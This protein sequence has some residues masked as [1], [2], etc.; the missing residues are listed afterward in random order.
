MQYAGPRR[1]R[2]PKASE[3]I[4][5]S[6]PRYTPGGGCAVRAR[7][8]RPP[9]AGIRAGKIVVGHELDLAARDPVLSP[10]GSWRWVATIWTRRC[11]V[12]RLARRRPAW[13]I[14]VGGDR[15]PCLP[16]VRGRCSSA[17]GKNIT[18]VGGNGDGQ[19]AK[20][21]NQIIVALTIEAVAEGLPVC[22]QG[23]RRS[24]Q[25]APG[26]DG[27]AGQFAYPGRAAW[28]SHADPSVPSIP[29]FASACI[30]RISTWL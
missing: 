27:W 20:V 4:I 5:L 17:L 22:F 16:T 23:R 28:R 12:A 21:A 25:G 7:R 29:A 3:V 19:T 15:K 8:E 30:R 1:R 18:L 10:T 9:H 24:G 2:L 26:A 14:M 11:R 13:T 6:A